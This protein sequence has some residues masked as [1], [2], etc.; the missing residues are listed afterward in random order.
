METAESGKYFKTQSRS[1]SFRLD[2]RDSANSSLLNGGRNILNILYNPVVVCRFELLMN[3]LVGV[4]H[5]KAGESFDAGCVAMEYSHK[6]TKMRPAR[7]QAGVYKI[8]RI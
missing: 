4:Y 5:R 7:M 8:L 2:R 6:H 1:C 3:S